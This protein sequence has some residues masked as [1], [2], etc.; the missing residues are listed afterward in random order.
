M[1][2][3]RHNQIYLAQNF[4]QSPMLVRRLVAKAELSPNDVVYEIGAGKGIITD[5]LAKTAAKV[6]AI[7]KDPRLVRRLREYFCAATHVEIIAQDFLKYKISEREYKVFAS[8]P[9]NV[10]AEIVRKLLYE[11]PSPSVA[12]L[13]MQKEAA[14]KFSGSPAETLFSVLAKPFFDFQI[15]ADLRRTDFVPVSKVDSVLLQI[16]RRRSPLIEKK[17][18]ASYRSFV[19]FGFCSWKRHLRAAYKNVFT[20]KQWKRLSREVGF[21]LNATPT[22]LS[23]EQWLQLYRAFTQ[24]RAE[25]RGTISKIL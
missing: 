4:L 9:Y 19:R 8:I 5:E 7:E 14:K 17:D 20:Y 3:R 16:R 13:V 1:G 24:M 2:K 18:S 22:D 15:V 10:T 23:F 12:W 21:P 11:G 6:I 25:R